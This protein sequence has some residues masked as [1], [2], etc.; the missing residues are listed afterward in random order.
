MKRKRTPKL[1]PLEAIEPPIMVPDY[2]HVGPPSLT[3]HRR[4]QPIFTVQAT[5]QTRNYWRI[6]L[7]NQNEDRQYAGLYAL[8]IPNKTKAPWGVEELAIACAHRLSEYRGTVTLQEIV[9]GWCCFAAVYVSN[10]MWCF[11]VWST[12]QERAPVIKPYPEG[13]QP[14]Q[15]FPASLKRT[16][17]EPVGHFPET[18]ARDAEFC[19]VA[20]RQFT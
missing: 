2:S 5:D 17:E 20:Q 14:G 9:E 4:V 19:K 12:D 18:G 11:C 16:G 3:L 8:V 15:D 6:A 7:L 10:S 13:W 1:I